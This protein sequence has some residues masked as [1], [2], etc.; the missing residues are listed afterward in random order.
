MRWT[1]RG[2]LSFALV[3]RR[4]LLTVQVFQVWLSSLFHAGFF[5]CVGHVTE[6]VFHKACVT[7][8]NECFFDFRNFFVV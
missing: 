5:S 8:P 6:E 2:M 7:M 1:R 3:I 4:L